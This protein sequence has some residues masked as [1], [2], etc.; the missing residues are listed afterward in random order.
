MHSMPKY[1]MQYILGELRSLVVIENNIMLYS[2]CSP[3][4]PKHGSVH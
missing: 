1:H 4:A 3:C 2:I